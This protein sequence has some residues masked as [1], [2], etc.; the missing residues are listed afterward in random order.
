MNP[1]PISQIP[2][3][4]QPANEREINKIILG[5]EEEMSRRVMVHVKL[6]NDFWNNPY[7]TPSEMLSALGPRGVDFFKAAAENIQQIAALSSRF[8]KSLSDFI[9]P[10][11]YTPPAELEFH[12][13]G[14]VTIPT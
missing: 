13:D 8:G 5:M 3:N 9:S 4:E 7:V 14:T 11:A 6:F 12:E 2:F 1:D 10:E